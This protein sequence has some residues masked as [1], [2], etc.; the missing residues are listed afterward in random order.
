[1][2]QWFEVKELLTALVTCYTSF[3]TFLFSPSVLPTRD[4][5]PQPQYHWDCC[6]LLFASC[7]FTSLVH[8]HAQPCRDRSLSSLRASR[9]R[10]LA[11]CLVTNGSHLKCSW[12]LPGCLVVLVR[13]AEEADSNG[14]HWQCPLDGQAWHSQGTWCSGKSWLHSFSPLVACLEF[15][16]QFVVFST[17][18][19]GVKAVN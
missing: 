8:I 5:Q 16:W 7:F 6:S 17:I 15:K 4:I 9:I 18:S 11:W 14:R 12:E 10:C 2:V 1:M 3:H 19:V 13:D